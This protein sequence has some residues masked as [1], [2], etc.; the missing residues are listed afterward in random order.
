MKYFIILIFSLL[1]MNCSNSKKVYWC[2]DHACIN[3]K[4]KES[5][6]KKTMIVEVRDVKKNNKKKSSEIELIE[7]QAEVQLKKEIKNE[8]ELAKQIRLEEKQR[9]KEAKELEKQ[10]R[11]E[12]KQRIKE[13]KELEKQTRLEEK[14][15]NKEAKKL[16]K[17][18]SSEKRKIEKQ[19]E[20]LVK[21]KSD[22]TK[23]LPLKAEKQTDTNVVKIYTSTDEFND[24][25]EKIK[26]KNMFRPFPSIN[27]IRD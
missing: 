21:K 23:K 16:A 13:A 4:E 12:E 15:K 6:F 1:L 10:V 19:N 5:Y 8:K 7:K 20:K 17:Q 22:V 14:R 27:D 18:A 9:I 24:L 25:V 26:K 3:K 11:F 2:G